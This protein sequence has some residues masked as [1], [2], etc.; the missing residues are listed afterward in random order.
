MTVYFRFWG[1]SP[2]ATIRTCGC[3]VLCTARAHCKADAL[4]GLLL[5]RLI[6]F[7]CQVRTKLD[8]FPLLVLFFAPA[9]T[10]REREGPFWV[11]AF[12]TLCVILYP[13]SPSLKFGPQ[14]S[15]KAF[16]R[17][18]LA[19]LTFRQSCGHSSFSA[20]GALITIYGFVCAR[21]TPKPF[22]LSITLCV[23]LS[24][25]MKTLQRERVTIL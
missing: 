4:A 22:P 21:V 12:C 23:F 1:P 11:C 16:L 19:F 2:V 18:H 15:S 6:S 24:C 25:S 17:G 13:Q 20:S 3:V 10:N 9:P 14:E 8:P 7:Q 5:L